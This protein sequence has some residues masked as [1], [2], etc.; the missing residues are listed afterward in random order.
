MVGWEADADVIF[1]RLQA[2]ALVAVG[3]SYSNIWLI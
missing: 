1:F 3:Y 2:L